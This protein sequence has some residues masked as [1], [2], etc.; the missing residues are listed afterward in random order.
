MSESV[1]PY[2]SD[3][4]KK[5]QVKTMFNNI[6]GR[7]DFLNRVLSMRVDV[8]WRNRAIKRLKKYQPKTI[9]DVACG[10][11]D[12]TIAA[13]KTGATKIIG[14]DISVQ[15]LEAGIKK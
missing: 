11:G 5:E 6:A 15:M 13:L 9:L 12:F 14:V 4:S 10:T 3:S 2:K 1:T 7:Y 8:Y